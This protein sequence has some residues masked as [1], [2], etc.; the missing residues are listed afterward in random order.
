[1][2]PGEESLMAAQ[3]RAVDRYVDGL[4]ASI[5]RDMK[6]SSGGFRKSRID[7]LEFGNQ[8]FGC[9]GMH[10]GSGRFQDGDC[11]VY[12]HHHHDEFCEM[13]TIDEIIMAGLD[14]RTFRPRSRI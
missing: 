9:A 2:T 10:R 8:Q 4:H 6:P 5:L 3:F 13:P 1:M 7:R 14:P 12:L 11:P